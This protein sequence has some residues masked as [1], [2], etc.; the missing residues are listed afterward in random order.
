MVHSSVSQSAKPTQTMSRPAQPHP[1]G[2]G[3]Q[4]LAHALEL[5]HRLLV[6]VVAADVEPVVVLGPPRP[7]RLAGVEQPQDQVREVEPLRPAR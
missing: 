2:I 4:P 6:V 3:Q 1:G 5:V 7:D